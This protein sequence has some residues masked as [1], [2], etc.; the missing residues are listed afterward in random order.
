MVVSFVIESFI[1][2]E[3]PIWSTKSVAFKTLFSQLSVTAS[4]TL[5]SELMDSGVSLIISQ[6]DPTANSSVHIKK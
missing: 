1:G 3:I 5:L 2:S 6:I 4:V